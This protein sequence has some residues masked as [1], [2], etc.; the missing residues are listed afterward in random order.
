VTPSAGGTP[1]TLTISVTARPASG[2]QKFSQ[3]MLLVSVTGVGMLVVLASPGGNRRARSRLVCLLT[4]SA[5]VLFNLSCGSSGGNSGGG[6]TTPTNFTVSVQAT[7]HSTTK[8]VGSV[9]VT[10]P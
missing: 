7:A 5:L 1:A 2:A 4:L 6:G 3:A 8:S 9:T 10:V